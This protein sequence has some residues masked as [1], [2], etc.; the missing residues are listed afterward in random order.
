MPQR[1]AEMWTALQK[2]RPRV[3]KAPKITRASQIRWAA[4]AKMAAA[5]MG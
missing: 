5:I 1:R 2:G 4:T 3:H